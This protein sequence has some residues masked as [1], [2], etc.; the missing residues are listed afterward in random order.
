MNYLYFLYGRKYSLC[1]N[2]K[3]SYIYFDNDKK[4]VSTVC[5]WIESWIWLQLMMD[6]FY[7][8]ITFTFK[9]YLAL[10]NILRNYA[11]HYVTWQLLCFKWIV[12]NCLHMQLFP[13]IFCGKSNTCHFIQTHNTAKHSFSSPRTAR[14][15]PNYS[16]HPTISHPTRL[17]T[18]TL[19]KHIAHTNDSKHAG[20]LC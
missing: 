3:Y 10:Q 19:N 14:T 1:E 9:L 11:V 6:Q 4:I 2:S 18:K 13:K 5:S 12:L 20:R 17:Q 15:K 7:H 16:T 8:T